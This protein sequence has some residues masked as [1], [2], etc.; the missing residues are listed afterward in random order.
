MIAYL[1]GTVQ[2][3]S[4]AFVILNVGGVGYEVFLPVS[5]LRRVTSGDEL[6]VFIYT[7]VKEDQ[8]KLFGFDS[9][10]DRDMFTL[11]LSISGVGP[12]AAMAILSSGS[13]TQIHKAVAEANVG[14]F[15]HV[16]GLGKKTA[17]KIII[18]LKTKLGSIKELD[19]NEE[20][21]NDFPND[22]VEALIGFGFA[23]KDIIKVLEK[24]DSELPEDRLMKLAIQK[25]GSL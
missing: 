22:V 17:Q 16:K 23:K 20:I 13:S 19:L 15:T 18:E 3:V 2:F 24:M 7:Y 14:F 1:I 10:V 12:K 4:P 5:S 21:E 6:A 9:L 8:L 11:L 25:L